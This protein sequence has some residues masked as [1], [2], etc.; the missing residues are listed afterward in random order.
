MTL[1]TD[2]WTI[3]PITG[4]FGVELVGARVTDILDAA[5]LSALLEKHLFVVLRKQFLTHAEQVD[6]ARALGEPTPAHPVVPGHPDHPEILELDAAK[7]GKNAAW[8]TDV[9]FSLTPPAASILV[10]DE[11]PAVGGDTLW[12]DLRSA[13]ERLAPP[14]QTAVSEMRAVHKIS[15]LAYWGEPYD[16]ALSRA[17][18]RQLLDD[19]ANVP[20]VIHPV[21]RIHPVTGRPSL[22]VNPGFTSHILDMSRIESDA[23]LGLLYAH[24]T[25]PELLVRHRWNEGDVVIW[26]NRSTMHYA[27]DDYSGSE[28]RMRRVTLAGSRP[29]GPNGIE[30]ELVTDP[31]TA[32]R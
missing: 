20:P 21:V 14:L 16:S 24:S 28:R 32:V 4:S 5:T 29:S 31:F 17:D 10:A 2:S 12:C 26:D 30:S 18:A 22:F 1:T 13:Y 9:T 8:H 25:R 7:G 6:L 15:P 19:A 3:T 27:I 11:L 23:L